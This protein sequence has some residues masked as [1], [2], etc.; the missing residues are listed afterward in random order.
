[1]EALYTSGVHATTRCTVAEEMIFKA[2]EV[3]YPAFV[4]GCCGMQDSLRP[5]FVRLTLLE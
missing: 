2:A 1:M 3:S 5:G 4:K